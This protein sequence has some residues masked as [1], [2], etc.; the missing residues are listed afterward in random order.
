MDT[1]ARLCLQYIIHLPL[2]LPL[3]SPDKY[4]IKFHDTKAN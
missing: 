2:A 1:I 4:T 3:P